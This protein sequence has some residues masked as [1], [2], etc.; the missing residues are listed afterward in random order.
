MNPDDFPN[1]TLAPFQGASYDYDLTLDMTD[2]NG[3]EIPDIVTDELDALSGP[4]PPPYYT[5]TKHLRQEGVA[6]VDRMAAEQ[7][8]LEHLPPNAKKELI[9]D[10]RMTFLQNE[11]LRLSALV[12][13]AEFQFGK[14][15]DVNR[16]HVDDAATATQAVKIIEEAF[17]SALGAGSLKGACPEIDAALANV[18]KAFAPPSIGEVSLVVVG[19]REGPYQSCSYRF[20]SEK[21]RLVPDQPRGR[22]ARVSPPTLQDDPHGQDQA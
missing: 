12:Q 17:S 19:S 2:I 6:F 1:T 15:H 9:T 20:D 18:G 3:D 21:R 10:W 5:G 16:A 7:V 14:F 8:G 4:S 11:V 22:T 13:S